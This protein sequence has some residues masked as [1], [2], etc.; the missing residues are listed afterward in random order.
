MG[1]P[2]YLR[3]T[4]PEISLANGQRHKSK[5][6]GKKKSEVREEL[7]DFN[8]RQK[9]MGK[10]VKKK[11]RQVGMQEPDPEINKKGE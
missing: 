3:R 8:K 6:K 7:Q 2:G 4:D 10:Q 9:T 11:V 5:V 1:S